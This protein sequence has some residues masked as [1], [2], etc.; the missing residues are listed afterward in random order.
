[1]NQKALK[2]ILYG[3]LI[4]GTIDVFAPEI[5]HFIKTQA[6]I[7]P[8]AVMRYIAG[9]V[10]GLDI[11]RV[12]GV[13]VAAFGML[14]QL[15]MSVLIAMIFVIAAVRMR[16]LARNWIA[17]GFV[18]GTIVFFVMNWV[19]VPLS[20]IGKAPQMDTYD[21]VANLVAM[22]LLG[23]IIAYFAQRNLGRA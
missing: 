6:W 19:V 5:I 17:A 23:L 11:A 12:G 7:S 8:L 20:M 13:P 9:G 16:W 15:L 10:V 2:A 3:G 22:W 18:Y 4:A 21:F 14:M 1:M